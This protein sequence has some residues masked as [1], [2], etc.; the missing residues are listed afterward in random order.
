MKR[1]LLFYKLNLNKTRQI[2]L[3]IDDETTLSDKVQALQDNHTELDKVLSQNN[4][5]FQ[6]L[7]FDKN[8]IFAS[9]GKVEDLKQGDHV[10]GR[11]KDNLQIEE[12]S[13]YIE[14]FSYFYI[15]LNTND[16][17]LIKRS[18]LPDI[19]KP[20]QSFLSLHFRIS[21]NWEVAV[22]PKLTENIENK[23]GKKVP[24]SRIKYIVEN[25]KIPDNEYLSINETLS[26]TNDDMTKVSVNIDL[27]Q[28]KETIIDK[29]IN[30]FSNYSE[31]VIENDT[32]T[33]DLVENI[34]TKKL[35]I[36]ID[37]K[38]LQNIESIKNILMNALRTNS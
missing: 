28:G 4:K 15:D 29:A 36:D 9:F 7:S 27:K 24:V 37:S 20:L 31:M 26:I 12:F 16:I 19:K 34:I 25:N 2:N 1:Q 38:S 21:G 17:A 14:T 11:N 23:I 13:H 3:F 30:K 35:T 33:I 18:G 8:H 10:R 6:L 5:I 22:V 32:E